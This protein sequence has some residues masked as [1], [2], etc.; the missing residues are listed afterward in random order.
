MSPFILATAILDFWQMSMPRDTGS[1]TIKKFDPE[2]LGTAVGILLC[3][4]EVKICPQLPAKV[5][6]N[7]CRHKGFTVCLFSICLQP[8]LYAYVESSYFP[9]ECINFHPQPSRLEK[10]SRE[11]NPRTHAYRG[12]EGNG[13]EGKG[14]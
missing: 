14:K 1:G 6:K 4:L 11:R 13:R 7:C 5:A 10:F 3:A 2:N 12:V 9:S 8:K